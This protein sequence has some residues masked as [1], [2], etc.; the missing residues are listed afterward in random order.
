[1]LD[2][3][4]FTLNYTVHPML[5]LQVSITPANAQYTACSHPRSRFFQSRGYWYSLFTS[6]F[7]SSSPSHI[8]CL[9]LVD[10]Q[11]LVD[12]SIVKDLLSSVLVL[13][14]LEL[15]DLLKDLASVQRLAIYTIPTI[16]STAEPLLLSPLSVSSYFL[17]PIRPITRQVRLY[18]VSPSLLALQPALP[19]SSLASMPSQ[20]SSLPSS[21]LRNVPS[22]I[23]AQLL[24]DPLSL[25]LLPCH[26]RLARLNWL[27]KGRNYL[28]DNMSDILADSPA[29]TNFDNIAGAKGVT[30]VVD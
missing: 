9:L 14:G 18:Y 26:N 4:F 1:M 11:S 10:V 22:S 23:S 16:T 27:P 12:L 29:R 20:L 25:P 30:G 2:Q 3:S 15:H 19:L 8:L 21:L 24:I 13:S 6:L 28:V 7:P 17:S 5:F